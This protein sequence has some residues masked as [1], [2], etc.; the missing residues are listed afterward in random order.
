MLDACRSLSGSG[1]GYAGTMGWR[2]SR[3]EAMHTTY[4]HVGP[5]NS[6]IG[7]CAL[8]V[9][10]GSPT[11]DAATVEGGMISARSLHSGGVNC[12]LADGSARFVANSINL[13]VWRSLATIAGHETVGGF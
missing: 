12:L 1:A 5:P 10:N 4:N 9:L 11:G 6:Q 13:G 2:W 3:S 7:D 8:S